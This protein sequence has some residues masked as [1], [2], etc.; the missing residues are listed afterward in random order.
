MCVKRLPVSREIYFYA[1]NVVLF[2]RRRIVSGASVTRCNGKG[3]VMLNQNEE[4]VRDAVKERLL[5]GR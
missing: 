5:P 2:V 4:T 3:R 1:V